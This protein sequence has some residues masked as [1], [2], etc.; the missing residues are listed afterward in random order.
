VKI[1][2]YRVELGEIEVVLAQHED[3]REC[4][5][6]LDDKG[7][8]NVNLWAYIVPKPG[9]RPSRIDLQSFLRNR[10]PEYMVPH[11][12][13]ELEEIPLTPSGKIDR[14]QLTGEG[15]REL[16]ES[17]HHVTPRDPH[18]S[19]IAAVWE[20]VL[21]I[22]P[23]GALDNFFDLGG[24]SMLALQLLSAVKQVTGVE[25][26]VAALFRAPTVEEQA[27]LLREREWKID[28]A[29]LIPIREGEHGKPIYFVHWAG[30]SVLVYWELVQLL[31]PALKVYGLQAYGLE[32]N[33]RPHTRIEQMAA[34]YV[35]EIQKI[36]PHGP[37]HLAGA[38]MGGS[39]AFEMARQLEAQGSQVGLV[40]LFDT[41]GRPNQVTLPL[42][43]RVRLHSG[44]IRAIESKN[45]LG[46]LFER[47]IIRLRRGFYSAVIGLGIP[48]PR[49]MWNLKQT[50][51]YA[52]KH[53]QPGSYSGDVVLFRATERGP[54]SPASLFL[55]WEDVVSGGIDI[56]DVPGK[57]G[58][59]LS[60]PNVQ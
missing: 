39:I 49:R 48:L 42:R 56:I 24:H 16:G 59:M 2:G 30:G 50:T 9:A 20:Q 35:A 57:H 29:S 53:Y 17:V 52:F 31:N 4:V 54:G 45:V 25:L 22:Q 13:F 32:Q 43:E 55:G 15:F 11:R 6:K 14:S 46:Y 33:V 58:T 18:E 40:A 44:N 41:V 36:Q 19:Q 34:H 60:E 23:V 5:I 37:Y 47:M 7:D 27:Q 8:S 1:R 3:V 28:G 51:R 38:S 21:G 26:S 12:F 10:L